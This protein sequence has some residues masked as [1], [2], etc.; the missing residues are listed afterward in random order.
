MKRRFFFFAF[1]FIFLLGGVLSSC[2]RKLIPM[3]NP[4]LVDS[5][6]PFKAPHF[7]KFKSSDYREALD[8]AMKQHLDEVMAITE[9]PEVPS[10]ENT[11]VALEKSG[12][13]LHRVSQIMNVLTG[14][15]SDSV[16]QKTEEEEAPRLAAHNDA[17]FLNN[18]LFQ[19]VSSLYDKRNSLGLDAE[20][21]R[22]LEYY[23]DKFLL[24]GARLDSVQQT[25]LKDLNQIE[26]SLSSQF[27]N[28]LLEGTRKSALLVTDSSALKG[29]SPDEMQQCAKKAADDGHPG[30][31]KISLQNTTQQPLLQ[32]LENRQTRRSLFLASYLRT[33]QT[34]SNDTRELIE[35]IAKV[36][37]EKATLL[38][39]RNYAD[40][41][42]KDQ[43]AKDPE[44]VFDFLNKLI[45]PAKAKVENESVEI[46]SFRKNSLDSA[47]VLEPWDWD[48][49]AEKVRKAKYALDESQL[50][51]YF[52][53][54]K[55]LIDGVFYA[56]GR[57]YG[58]SFKERH[59]IPVYQPDV[60]VFEVFD[61][62]GK[63]LGLFYCDY[64]KRD[65]KSGGAWMDNI[66][67][68]SHLLNNKPVIYN[69]ANF[70]KPEPGKPA[71]LTFDN[72]VTMF[73]E[74]GHALH[75]FFADQMYPS[76]SGTSVARDFVEFPSQ[77]NE[78]WALDPAVLAHYA[79]HYKTGAPMPVELVNKIRR[80]ATFNQGYALSELLEAAAL[81][82]K[83][84]TITPGEQL[85]DVDRFESASLKACGLDLH[86]VPP[87][88]RSSYFL[89]IWGNGYAAGYYA[90]LWAEMLDDD[91]YSWFLQHGG[92]NRANGDRFRHLILSRGNSED[93]EKIFRDF[94]GHDPRIGPML[95]NR[96]IADKIQ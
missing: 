20:S 90:Y 87:R 75:G 83:W 85:S 39:Y 29:L 57:L 36:R 82:M 72:V 51:P 55:V 38:G 8:F 4:L 68:Q 73:H 89:H 77:F 86:A 61:F 49:Y 94:T 19:R 9:N 95:I 40:W 66:V 16:L 84:H 28:R 3:K 64:F 10:F 1:A 79:V 48:F 26:A 47:G 22:L 25:R 81:D 56:A 37:C 17:I 11:L 60:R 41:T 67:T 14:A 93:L 43:M 27:V 69:V 35:K 76:L 15:N 13:L 18:K 24:S 96:G 54:N 23:Y 52:E 45:T 44:R 33:E 92:L 71:L 5:K 78:H 6:L 70:Q 46:D 88:Y 34:D 12:Q 59:D 21:L 80:S 2:N 32:V 31:W 42:L 63:P 30:C 50:K 65:N 91:A 62:D 58:L 53:L 7:E 74:F